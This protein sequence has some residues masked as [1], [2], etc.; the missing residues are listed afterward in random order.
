MIAGRSSAGVR[1][2]LADLRQEVCIIPPSV[3]TEVTGELLEPWNE[4]HPPPNLRAC[5]SY[6]FQVVLQS[7]GLT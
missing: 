1:K 6:N 2:A 3:L 4:D 7:R 5:V